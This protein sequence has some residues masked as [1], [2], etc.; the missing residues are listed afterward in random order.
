VRLR[1]D[2]RRARGICGRWQGGSTNAMRDEPAAAVEN[3]DPKWLY[4]EAT[5]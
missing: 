2:L 4:P 1:A 5:R 3:L